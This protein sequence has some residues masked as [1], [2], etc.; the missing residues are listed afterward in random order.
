MTCTAEMIWKK[1]KKVG[2]GSYAIANRFYG[3]CHYD[4]GNMSGERP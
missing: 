2:C 4:V 3:V 1:A